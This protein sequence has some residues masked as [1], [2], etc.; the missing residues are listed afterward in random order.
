MQLITF[1]SS[2]KGNTYVL[3]GKTS[4]L[5]IE[6][7][8]DFLTVH[9]KVDYDLICGCVVTHRH[10]DHCKYIGQYMSQC[11]PVYALED[12][13][14]AKEASGRYAKAITPG[15]KFKVG[16]F[17]IYPFAANHDVPCVGF[18]I[19]HPE[20]GK[21]L[22]LT[23][24]FMSE[25][26][27]SGLNQI[28]VECNYSEAILRECSDYLVMRKRL[29]YSHMELKTTKALLSANDLSLVQN[30]VLVHLSDGHSH[31]R[32]FKAEIEELTEKRVTV[33]DRGRTI[34]FNLNPY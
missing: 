25:Y 26:T 10:N 23:D 15:E 30:I 18:I 28:I 19:Y 3:Q 9:K 11:V 16:E 6:A 20:C 5:V 21:V 27:F 24:T 17:Q 34:D 32:H 2:S 22:F 13:F 8:V 7:G 14:Q 4:A 33:A 12:V 1:G 31:E 29:M